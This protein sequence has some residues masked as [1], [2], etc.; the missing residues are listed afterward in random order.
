MSRPK[1]R[2]VAE[3][4]VG[5]PSGKKMEKETELSDF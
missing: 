2:P 4:E 1:I 3:T 5:D